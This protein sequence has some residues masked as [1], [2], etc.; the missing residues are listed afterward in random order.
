MIDP[1]AHVKFEW[2]SK[3][4][5]AR[6]LASRHDCAWCTERELGNGY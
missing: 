4:W 6:A 5:A 2:L 1:C 3:V